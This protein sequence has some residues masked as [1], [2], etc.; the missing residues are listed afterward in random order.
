MEMYLVSCNSRKKLE[1]FFK[2]N[3][4][5]D[6]AIGMVVGAAFTQIVNSFVEGEVVQSMCVV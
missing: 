5:K 4:N 2:K 6:L 1:F 3:N